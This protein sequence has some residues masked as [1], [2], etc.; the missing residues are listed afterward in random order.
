MG[1]GSLD[2]PGFLKPIAKLSSIP[3]PENDLGHGQHLKRD[4]SW[5]LSTR[6]FQ[7]GDVDG[8][9][10]I[11]VRRKPSRLRRSAEDRGSLGGDCPSKDEA[12]SH[13]SERHVQ[14]PRCV[15]WRSGRLEA[16]IW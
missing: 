13:F 8:R 6:T 14:R 3:V 1:Q 5:S 7:R 2:S 12:A 9:W 10:P 11:P 4:M 16:E 15:A